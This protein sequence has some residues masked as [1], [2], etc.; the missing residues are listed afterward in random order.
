MDAV[1]QIYYI[2]TISLSILASL[3]IIAYHILSG[4]EEQ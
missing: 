2:V 1:Y 3:L 4:R